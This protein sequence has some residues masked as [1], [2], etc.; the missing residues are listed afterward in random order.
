MI[1]DGSQWLFGILYHQCLSSNVKFWFNFEAGT[2]P[3]ESHLG[4]NKFIQVSTRVSYPNH[5]DM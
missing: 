5:S 4:L 1:S 2:L 3:T